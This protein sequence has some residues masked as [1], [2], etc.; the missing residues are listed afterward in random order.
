MR[1]AMK[2]LFNRPLLPVQGLKSAP[3]AAAHDEPLIFQDN[4]FETEE[5][6]RP[7][8]RPD[9]QGPLAAR[10]AHISAIS[11][12]FFNMFCS[13]L[14]PRGS[15]PFTTSPFTCIAKNCERLLARGRS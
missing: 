14:K 2:S 5:S 15:R 10:S 7:S 3:E 11:S 12:A 6:G 8:T 9:L 1:M 13:K 4:A